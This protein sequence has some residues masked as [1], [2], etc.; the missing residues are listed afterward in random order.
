MRQVQQ[1]KNRMRGRGRK[2]PNHTNRS[3]E[4]NGP[5]VKIRGN[6]AH[7]AEKYA[8][9]A[10]D[11]FSSGDPVLGENYLQHA[12]HYN[13]I[14]AATQPQRSEENGAQ[15]GHYGRGPQPEFQGYQDGEEGGDDQPAQPAEFPGGDAEPQE[16]R[17]PGEGAAY[18]G[19]QPQGGQS[20]G[21][22]SQGG[23]GQEGGDYQSR[24]HRN[25]RRFRP[26]E[27]GQRDANYR[28]HQN[29]DNN[30]RDNTQ[31]D[32]QFRDQ[33]GQDGGNGE[34]QVREQGRR[35][36][37]RRDESRRDFQREGQPQANGNGGEAAKSQVSSDASMLPQSLFGGSFGA[38]KPGAADRDDE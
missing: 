38:A 31:R 15:S 34:S 11:A 17:E 27:G 21:G 5:D 35:E 1:Q 37:H 12:E 9:L 7:I 25:R 13:R 18:Q 28:D 26:G 32:R 20:Q 33:R 23:Q 22:Q 3:F 29:R 36:E 2:M 30:P 16:G 24:H 14:V 10:R 6:A 19:G 4:S 8:S